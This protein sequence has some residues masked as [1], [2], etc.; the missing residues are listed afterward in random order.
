VVDDGTIT[1][2]IKRIPQ[3]FLAIDPKFDAIDTAY[4]MATGGA[5]RPAA[6]QPAGRS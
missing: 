6:L 4:G 3:K 5:S 2:H 1:S